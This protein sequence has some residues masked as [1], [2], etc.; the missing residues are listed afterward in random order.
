MALDMYLYMVDKQTKKRTLYAYMSQANAIH[1]FFVNMAQDGFDDNKEYPLSKD[2][3]KALNIRCTAVIKELK[4]SPKEV[5]QECISVEK[6]KHGNTIEK[7]EELW[8]FTD[9]DVSKRI[10][11]TQLGLGFGSRHYD[12]VYFNYVKYAH[13]ICK[14]ILRSFD[15]DKYDLYYQSNW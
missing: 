3:I 8:E 14:K 15:F 2:I 4:N 5:V 9:T 12:E 7:Y 11:P 1:K 6:D 13:K 10:L